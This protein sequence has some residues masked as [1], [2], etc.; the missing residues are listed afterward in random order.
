[1][2]VHSDTPRVPLDWFLSIWLDLSAHSANITFILLGRK[3][4]L[5]RVFC[6][7]LSENSLS[8]DK[9]TSWLMLRRKTTAVCR[10]TRTVYTSAL[11]GPNAVHFIVKLG[12]A[13]GYRCGLKGCRL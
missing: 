10:G 5:S 7:Y 1:M 2:S 12:D 8:F 13:Y 3:V 11:Y 9:M 4:I 6:S